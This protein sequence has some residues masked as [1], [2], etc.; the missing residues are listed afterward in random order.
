MEE[1]TT[2]EQINDLRK[3]VLAGKEFS[4]EEYSK[5]IRAYH[6]FRLAGATSIAPKVTERAAAAKR[7]TPVDLAT[8]L[9]KLKSGG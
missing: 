1:I 4:V 6:A 3:Q 9:A 7:A 8:I 5:I 2:V